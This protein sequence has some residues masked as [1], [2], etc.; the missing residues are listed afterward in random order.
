MASALAGWLAIELERIEEEVRG[1]V[2]RSAP[3]KAASSASHPCEYGKLQTSSPRCVLHPQTNPRVN[4]DLP[5]A[6]AL[7]SP[8]SVGNESHG[9]ATD[10]SQLYALVERGLAPRHPR[11]ERPRAPPARPLS[12]LLLT[13]TLHFSSFRRPSSR[14]HFPSLLPRLDPRRDHQHPLDTATHRRQGLDGRRAGPLWIKVDVLRR[15]PLHSSSRVNINTLLSSGTRSNPLYLFA[16]ASSVSVFMDDRRESFA[17]VD[18]LRCT[19]ALTARSA[20]P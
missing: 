9:I 19:G 2:A 6:R 16:R 4:P 10:A 13:P 8:F 3:N 20:S 11:G 15:P 7:L 12:L 1:K 17:A 5:S 18:T 14:S